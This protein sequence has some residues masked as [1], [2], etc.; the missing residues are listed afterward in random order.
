VMN[1]RRFIAQCLAC[2]RIRNSTQGSAALR[3]FDPV[4]VPDGS[5][6]SEVIAGQILEGVG[7]TERVAGRVLV[8]PTGTA[9]T[10]EQIDGICRVIQ[11]AIANAEKVNEHLDR[12]RG[13]SQIVEAPA[14]H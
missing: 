11:V 13:G 2:F 14:A 3:D 5:K 8:L 6:A 4:Y 12:K 10:P 9:V 7:H 1:S